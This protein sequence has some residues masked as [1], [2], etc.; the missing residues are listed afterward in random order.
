M[1]AVPALGLLA[2]FA[3]T[4][5]LTAAGTLMTTAYVVLGGVYLAAF[6]LAGFE[7]H[8]WLSVSLLAAI[9][10]HVGG[11]VL[12]GVSPLLGAPSSVTADAALYLG[13]VLGLQALF[14]IG[15]AP[16]VSQAKHYR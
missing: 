12:L 11:G 15:L 14:L 6:L 8:L 4:G 2:W 10:V 9:A 16:L 3:A 7:R 1:T 13:S 5:R